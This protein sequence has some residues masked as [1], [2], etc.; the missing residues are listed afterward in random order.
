MCT[1]RLTYGTK[2]CNYA[3]D[4]TL[5]SCNHEVKT[6]IKK[7]EQNANH[8]K[9]WFPESHKKLN[10]D[11]FH[12]IICRTKEEKVNMHVGEVQIEESDD[13]K[14]LGI[15]LDK[16]LTFIKPVQATCKKASQKR[17]ALTCIS[18]NMKP[19]TLKLLMKAQVMSQFS[20]CSLVWMFHERNLNNRIY[21][22]L[23]Q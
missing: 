5:Y 19:K 9:T 21:T 17:H 3:D 11:K 18:I 15:T 10:E 23:K 13:K 2:I 22:I 1:T 8:L 16:K 12:L 4:T 6:A 7:L 14:L 20:Y